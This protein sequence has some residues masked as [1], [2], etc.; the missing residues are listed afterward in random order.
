M[1]IDWGHLAA[2]IAVMALVLFIAQKA[3]IYE[4]GEKRFSWK[5]FGLL[6]VALTILNI[7]WPRGG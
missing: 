3:G 1:D 4:K 5:L 6:L 7:A 2:T